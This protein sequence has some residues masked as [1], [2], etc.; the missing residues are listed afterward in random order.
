MIQKYLPVYLMNL[1]EEEY[2]RNK[3]ILIADK[4]FTSYENYELSIS[5]YKIVP[6]IFPKKNMDKDKTLGKLSY[7]LD[8]FKGKIPKKQIL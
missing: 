5:R 8:C 4:G 3:D 1:K 7:P 6:L 2:M